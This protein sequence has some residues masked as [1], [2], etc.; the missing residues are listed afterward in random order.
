MPDNTLHWF[1]GTLHNIVS[2]AM[3]DLLSVLT[4]VPFV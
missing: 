1:Y 2:G 4:V 3:Y